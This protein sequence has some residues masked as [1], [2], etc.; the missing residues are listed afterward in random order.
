MSR[1]DDNQAITRTGTLMGSPMRQ[2]WLPAL[3]SSGC[4]GPTVRPSAPCCWASG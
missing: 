3:L 1:D 4:P 2:Y